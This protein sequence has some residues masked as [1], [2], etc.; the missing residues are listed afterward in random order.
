MHGMLCM[1]ALLVHVPP[2]NVW[3]NMD[4]MPGVCCWA[5]VPGKAHRTVLRPGQQHSQGCYQALIAL[6]CRARLCI[7]LLAHLH[8]VCLQLLLLPVLPGYQVLHLCL[9]ALPAVLESCCLRGQR[10]T[11]MHADMV[12]TTQLAANKRQDCNRTTY[13]W[14]TPCLSRS[15]ELSATSGIANRVSKHIL[16]VTT[17][18]SHSYLSPKCSSVCCQVCIL[19]PHQAYMQQRGCT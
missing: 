18:V 15:Q 10:N 8:S 6:A 5:S 17:R 16:L 14:R 13:H 19:G 1:C 11:Y 12:S 4:R 7:C 3:V 2:A 9:A